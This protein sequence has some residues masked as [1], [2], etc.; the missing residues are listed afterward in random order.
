MTATSTLNLHVEHG[1]YREQKNIN[2]RILV[3]KN[4]AYG[5]PYE[6]WYSKK[7]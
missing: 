2:V 5:Y 3:E 1:L 6:S 7:A 4:Y